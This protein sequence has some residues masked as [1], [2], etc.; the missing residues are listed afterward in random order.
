[1]K[2]HTVVNNFVNLLHDNDIL[3]F[4]GKELCKEV[5]KNNKPNHFYIKESIGV[6][7][8]F[9]LGIAMCT[10]KRI[11]V[12]VGEG[13]LLRELGVIAQIGAS[14][15]NN[16]FLVLLDNGCY[17]SAGGYPTVFENMLSKKGFIYNS[18]TKVITFT[19][20]FKD[21]EFKRLKD[22]FPRLIGPMVVLMDVDKGIKRGLEEVDIDFGEQR[23]R[24]SKFILDPTKETA[25]FVPPIL[26][27]PAV[28]TKT[29]NIDMLKT[30]GTE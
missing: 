20:H 27:M 21:R 3:I 23:D 16:I 28:D 2:R 26:S 19:K 25:M 24:I 18:N 22:R 4:S 15:C 29:L 9:G 1:M 14:K 6:A 8:P 10:D 13:E 11:F 5:Y 12:F 17:Q 30:G 7:I